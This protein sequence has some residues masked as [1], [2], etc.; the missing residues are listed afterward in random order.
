MFE[1]FRANISLPK[2]DKS[3][4]IK[5]KVRVA[6]IVTR[7]GEI[8]DVRITSKPREYLDNEVIQAM[9]K[10]PKWK[11]GVNDGK[12]ADCYYLLDIQF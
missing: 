5:G 4:K 7:E 3:R 12:I 2:V 10:M 6:F 8:C 1:F 11:P 9:K